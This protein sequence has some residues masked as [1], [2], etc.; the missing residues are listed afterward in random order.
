MEPIRRLVCFLLLLAALGVAGAGALQ[1]QSVRPERTFFLRPHVGIA[2]YVGDN[3]KALFNFDA[4]FPYTAGLDLGYQFSRPL[5]LSAGYV[6]GSYP[7]VAT[8][9]E[10]DLRHTTRLLLRYTFGGA[11][12]VAPYLQAGAHATF[13]E[14]TLAG[15]ATETRTAFGPVVGLGL[16]VPLSGRVSLFFEATTHAAFPDD[17]ADG[18][19]DG[20]SGGFDLLSSFGTGIKINLG[21]AV[22]PRVL[23]VEGP[24]RLQAGDQGTFTAT[25]NEARATRPV[26]YRWDWGDGTSSTGLTATHRYAAAGSYTVRFTATNRAGSDTATRTVQVAEAT[27]PATIVTLTANPPDPDTRT[28]VRFDASV[29]GTAPLTYAWD[30]GDGTTSTETNPSHT[31]DEPGTYTVTLVVSNAAGS[32][33]RTTTVR[34]RPYVAEICRDV[35]EMNAVFFERNA[36]TLSAT[37]RR[38][39]DENVEILLE[40]PNINVRLEG[41]AGP[42]ERQPQRLSEDRARAVEAYYREGGVA[43]SRIDLIG[44][45]AP[46]GTTGKKDG[47]AQFQ[48][49]DTIPLR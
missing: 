21:G 38:T 45:G 35:T 23:S 36:S 18:R 19:D 24:D 40:C 25:V 4:A 46:R 49:V 15:G 39:L 11:T 9:G 48:R 34:V 43:A 27:V 28:A 10:N 12:G 20:G 37:A 16:D 44:R 6:L 1:A 17:A 8:A 31:F 32:D 13:G 47:T 7:G 26:T 29:R 5:S 3:E 42:G 2:S 41:H 30:F 14:V 33:R 22:A